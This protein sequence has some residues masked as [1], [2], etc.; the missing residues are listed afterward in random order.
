MNLSGRYERIH[1]CCRYCRI[2]Y[3]DYIIDENV[4]LENLAKNL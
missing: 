1:K 2:Y 3:A 4:M